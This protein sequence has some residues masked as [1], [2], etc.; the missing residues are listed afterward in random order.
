ML[1]LKWCVVATL[2]HEVIVAD[3]VYPTILLVYG[4]S[5]GLLSA[6][7]GCLQSGLRVLCRSFC[8]VVTEED[9]EGNMIIGPDGEPKM[10]T[11]N[12]HVELPY[13]YIMAGYIMHCPYLMS[14]VQSSED[15]MP[16]LQ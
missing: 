9:K 7:V 4:R 10:K 11:H 14:I 3:I 12:P 15:S 8:N 1:W 2:P 5:L 6:K 13:T 16:F